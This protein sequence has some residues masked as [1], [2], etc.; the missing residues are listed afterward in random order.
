M[1]IA[2]IGAGAWGTAL[3]ILAGRAGHEVRLWSRSAEV[4]GEINRGRTNS[5]YLAGYELPSGVR[6]TEDLGAALGGA[7][8][9]LLVAPSHAL[10]GL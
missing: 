4:V 8:V 2:V 10:R 7:G 1:K 5:A 9:V 6:A 3:S